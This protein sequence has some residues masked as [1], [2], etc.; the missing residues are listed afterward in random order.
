MPRILG[1]TPADKWERNVIAQLKQQLPDDWV[2][3]SGVAWSR[4]GPTTGYTYVRD[5]QADIV[6]L[7]PSLGMVILE[8]KGSKGFR[9]GEDGRWYRLGPYGEEAI[10][11]PPPD[12]ASSN[13]HELKDLVKQKGPWTDFPGLHAYAVVYPQGKLEGQPP[14]NLDL[15]TIVQATQMNQLRGR[16]VEALEARGPRA[17]G[18]R[19]TPAVLAE[20]SRLLTSQPFS[21]VKVDTPL[22]VRHDIDGVELLTRQQFAALQ[23]IFNLPRV[24]V[25]GP[26]GSGKTVLAMWLL[27][28]MVE[29]GKRAAYVCYNTDLATMLRRK[30]PELANS[31]DNVDRMF[32][33]VAQTA[34]TLPPQRTIQ[35]DATRFFRD[36]LPGLVFDDVVDWPAERRYDAIIVD[37]GQ[38]FGD[39]QLLALLEMLPGDG[40]TYVHFADQR[41][42]L[43]RPMTSGSVGAEVQF[44]LKHNCRNTERINAHTNRLLAGQAI[45]SMPGVPS[46]VDPVVKFCK[47]S[48]VMAAQAW[49]LAREW[50]V[51]GGS[52][53]ILSPHRL[54]N[55]CMAAAT[56]GHGLRL[57]EEVELLGVGENVYFSTIR[58]FKGI[59][60]ASVI[61]VDVD[62]PQE[63]SSFRIED[64]YVACTRPTAR[65]ALLA[66]TRDA[67][68]W[69]GANVGQG[70]P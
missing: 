21:V 66:K 29:Q 44:T 38:D 62:V 41:Q 59:E 16:L 18:A 30:H 68:S 20:V 70:E 2:V 39:T 1:S 24:A 50:H 34:G 48:G 43:F 52:V 65:L 69:L 15:T 49:Q 3:I 55:S 14:T 61:V 9:I 51:E 33:R 8:V 31:I 25:T 67:T 40:G 53:V 12:Q 10:S 37:E 58:S 60:A 42:D 64:L 13:M 23:G 5:G 45:P 32:R 47:D 28:A 63:E 46:G 35:Q 4:R 19:F 6:V 54:D 17:T 27:Q 56:K 11:T 57:V 36:E 26:A 7:V 22:D